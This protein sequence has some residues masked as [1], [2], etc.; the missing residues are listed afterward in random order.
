[1]DVIILAIY[2][3]MGNVSMNEHFLIIVPFSGGF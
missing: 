1:M 3:D 2:F